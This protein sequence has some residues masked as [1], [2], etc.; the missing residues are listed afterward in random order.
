MQESYAIDFEGDNIKKGQKIHPEIAEL[1]AAILRRDLKWQRK[2]RA[3]YF[4]RRPH[5]DLNELFECEQRM[6]QQ[7][8]ENTIDFAT[9]AG[10]I[11][12]R[13]A[14]LT[15]TRL[16]LNQEQFDEEL[17]KGEYRLLPPKAGEGFG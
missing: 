9:I 14:T 10:F 17:A 2:F 8:Q 6:L 3:P 15:N 12:I 7:G 5:H 1:G 16:P 13:I 11:V 4:L